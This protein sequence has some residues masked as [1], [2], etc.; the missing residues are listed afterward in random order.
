MSDL[1]HGV[2]CLNEK[3]AQDWHKNYPAMA[4]MFPEWLEARSA[5]YEANKGEQLLIGNT[6][7]PSPDQFAEMAD[8]TKVWQT[9]SVQ[10]EPA[11]WKHDCA[12]LLQNDVELWVDRCPH[13]GKPSA[14]PPAAPEKGKE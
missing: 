12:A 13:C 9:L 7:F 5:S 1:E 10:Q 2:K 8:K 3:A 4:T 14:T 6:I 11:A